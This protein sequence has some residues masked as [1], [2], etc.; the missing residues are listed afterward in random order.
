MKEKKKKNHRQNQNQ[1]QQSTTA[2]EENH[3]PTPAPI[4]S[5]SAGLSVGFVFRSLERV[6]FEK[7]EAPVMP[8]IR[9]IPEEQVERYKYR[10]QKERKK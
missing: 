7:I 9:K 10:D 3:K 1:Q 2:G 6:Q 8:A 5:G 4:F